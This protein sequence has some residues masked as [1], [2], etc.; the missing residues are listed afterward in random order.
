MIFFSQ[1]E[2]FRNNIGK[3]ILLK[4]KTTTTIIIAIETLH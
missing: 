4:T 2:G 3:E 1:N